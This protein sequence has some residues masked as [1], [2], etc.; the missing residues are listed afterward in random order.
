MTYKKGNDT[1]SQSQRNSNQV[2][3]CPAAKSVIWQLW[4]HANF[5]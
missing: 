3:G 1:I 4:T 5:G 2:L